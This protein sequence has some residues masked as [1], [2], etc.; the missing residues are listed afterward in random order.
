MKAGY[1]KNLDKGRSRRKKNPD[2]EE[3]KIDVESRRGNSKESSRERKI[4]E[5]REKEE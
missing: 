3:I 4:E 2:K 1:S 5:L